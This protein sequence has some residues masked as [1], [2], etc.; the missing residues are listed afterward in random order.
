MKD[1]KRRILQGLNIIKHSLPR[2]S[3]AVQEC[4]KHPAHRRKVTHLT[5]CTIHAPI[6]FCHFQRES[7]DDLALK[8]STAITSIIH[9]VGKGLEPED[10]AASTLRKV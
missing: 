10:T 6:H 9:A 4:V 1:T 5:T 3:V 2:F 7:R 8:I